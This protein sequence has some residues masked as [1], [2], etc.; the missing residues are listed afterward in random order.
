VL[1]D[2]TV[3][4]LSGIKK[5]AKLVPISFKVLQTLLDVIERSFIESMLGFG[6]RK[7]NTKIKVL[8]PRATNKNKQSKRKE[9]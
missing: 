1:L 9:K 6:Y 5:G 8:F 3:H 4:E 2:K 7:Q